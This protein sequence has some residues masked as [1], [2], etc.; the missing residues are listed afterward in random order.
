MK[1]NV[2]PCDFFCSRVAEAYLLHLV[3]TWRRPIYRYETGDIEVCKYFLWGLL[4]RCPKNRMN[5]GYRARF[6]SKLLKEFDATTIKGAVIHGG[7]VPELNSRGVKYM[8]ALVHLYG[9]TLT[10]IGVQDEYGMLIP[11]ESYKGASL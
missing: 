5:D 4:D 6:Y 3:A 10:D 8:N 7:K 11:P 1:D 9:D 2:P